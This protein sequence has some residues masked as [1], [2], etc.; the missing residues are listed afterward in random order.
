MILL[1][2]NKAAPRGCSSRAVF[3]CCECCVVVQGLTRSACGSV[4]EIARI[5]QS[6]KHFLLS[7][8]P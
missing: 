7:M 3:P 4:S 1:F 5:L 6:V 8:F 2:L